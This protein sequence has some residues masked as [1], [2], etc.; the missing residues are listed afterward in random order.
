MQYIIDNNGN[1]PDQYKHM[2][3][4]EPIINGANGVIDNNEGELVR[5]IK[6]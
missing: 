1:T 2:K 4:I 3:K 5:S 6:E